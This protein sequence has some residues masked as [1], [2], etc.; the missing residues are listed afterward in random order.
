MP[1]RTGFGRGL[2]L[3]GDRRHRPR[4]FFATDQGYLMA[5]GLKTGEPVTSFGKNGAVDVYTGVASEGRRRKPPR[6]FHD[7][8]SSNG[9]QNLL[10]SGARQ[11]SN[12]RHSLVATFE[13]G[14]PSRES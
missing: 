12:R 2:A 1:R 5:V 9:L 10:I 14:M 13:P 3:A 6:H 11:V 7:S 8:E 4:L